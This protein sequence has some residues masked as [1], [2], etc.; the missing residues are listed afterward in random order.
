MEWYAILFW[1]WFAV[2]VVILVLRRLKVIG[3]GR[4]PAEEPE[5]VAP[6]D[7]TWAPPPPDP[8]APLAPVTAGSGPVI[9]A[10]PTLAEL[11]AGITLPHELVPLTQSL[12]TDPAT[13]LVVST[14]SASAEVVGTGLA[15]ELERLGYAVAPTGERTA[16]AEGARG[17]VEL[18]VHADGA[19]VFDGGARRFPTADAGSVVVVLRAL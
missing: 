19:T 16:I 6:L 4:D 13:E 8:D 10:R 11:L 15:D 7:R 14:R 9:G 1:I 2:S 12:G 5:A 18:E 3:A 17:R